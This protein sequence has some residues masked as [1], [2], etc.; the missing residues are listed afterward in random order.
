MSETPLEVVTA[1]TRIADENRR[2]IAIEDYARS[3]HTTYGVVARQ[4]CRKFNLNFGRHVEDVAQIIATKDYELILA[5]VEDPSTVEGIRDWV[6]MLRAKCRNDVQKHVDTPS[7]AGELGGATM[8]NRRRREISATRQKLYQAGRVDVTDEEVV[9]ETN[10]RIAQSY[11]NPAKNGLVCSVDDLYLTVSSLEVVTDQSTDSD[12]GGLLHSTEAHVIVADAIE[13]ASVESETYGV[14][15]DTYFGQLFTNGSA[16]EV[17]E[18][19]AVSSI[20]GLS[21]RECAAYKRKGLELMRGMLMGR[22]GID[23][24]TWN[25]EVS[26]SKKHRQGGDGRGAAA[27]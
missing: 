22:Y 25:G 26:A 4:F 12:I 2:N 3:M 23:E 10:A 6:G 1:I 17:L 14:V 27:G 21:V 5:A 7:G 24:D 15:L 13:Q 18:D 8:L 9:A 19:K 11:K 16:G 20:T